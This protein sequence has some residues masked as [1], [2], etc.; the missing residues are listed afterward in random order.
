MKELNLSEILILISNTYNL[1]IDELK[2]LIKTNLINNHSNNNSN[3]NYNK[4]M[5]LINNKSTKEIYQCT[6][7]STKDNFCKK[8][9]KMFKEGNLK[10]GMIKK[11]ENKKND[12]KKEKKNDNL[13]NYTINSTNYKI[14]PLN[15]KL[16]D[17]YTNNY[18]GKLDISNNDILEDYVSPRV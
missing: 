17:F 5:A 4:C 8:H 12:L 2:K 18:I 13:Q 1:N 9:F 16:Y 3:I 10:H 14:N 7:N 6:R 11:Q 15:L